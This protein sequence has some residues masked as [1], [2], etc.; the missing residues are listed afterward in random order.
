[1]WMPTLT[2]ML[3]NVEIDEE[4]QCLIQAEARMLG[5]KMSDSEIVKLILDTAYTAILYAH[6]PTALTR[7]SVTIRNGVQGRTRRLNAPPPHTFSVEP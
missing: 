3:K 4:D 2:G 6:T 1:M 7:P 5:L